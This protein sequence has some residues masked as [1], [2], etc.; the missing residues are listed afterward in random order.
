VS[1][2]RTHVKRPARLALEK[3]II[4]TQMDLGR[5]SR[6]PQLLQ[7]TPTGFSLFIFLITN[8]LRVCNPLGDGD[9]FSC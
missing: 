1:E 7:V 2:R 3:H 6:G 4:T 9:G 8:G 5:F